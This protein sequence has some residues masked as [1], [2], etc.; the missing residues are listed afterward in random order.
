[1]EQLNNLGLTNNE[2]DQKTR[3]L[4]ETQAELKRIIDNNDFDSV[5]SKIQAILDA[6]ELSAMIGTIESVTKLGGCEV[7]NAIKAILINLQNITSDKIVDTLDAANASM[8]E[9]VNGTEKHRNPI[10]I[11]RDLAKTF[12]QLDENDPLRAEILTNIGQ[13]YHTANLVLYFKTWKCLIRCSMIIQKVL[14]LPSKNPI[15]VPK[16]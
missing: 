12:N 1:M 14:V 15:K 10:D 16:T 2:I 4:T 11:L 8:T 6:D 7:G 13:K 5:N 9:F 3:V